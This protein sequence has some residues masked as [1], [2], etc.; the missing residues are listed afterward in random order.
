[1]R[2]DLVFSALGPAPGR[3]RLCRLT[4]QAG[5]KLHARKNRIQDTLNDVLLLVSNS[6]SVGD[7]VTGSEKAD[8]EVTRNSVP[9]LSGPAVQMARELQ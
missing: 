2:S 7:C 8:C 1:M 9:A 6:T 3:Y 5:R 4:A